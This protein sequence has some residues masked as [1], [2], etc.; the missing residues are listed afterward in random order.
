MKRYVGSVVFNILPGDLTKREQEQTADEI[1]TVAADLLKGEIRPDT[2]LV[3]LLIEQVA[4][5]AGD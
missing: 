2:R 3:Q 4:D 1:S 5:P